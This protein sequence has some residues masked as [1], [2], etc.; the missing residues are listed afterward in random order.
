MS[1][2]SRAAARINKVGFESFE[3]RTRQL[4]LCKRCMQAGRRNQL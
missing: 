1:I 3:T 2:N 4:F